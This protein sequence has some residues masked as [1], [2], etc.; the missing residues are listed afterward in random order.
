MY[1]NLIKFTKRAYNNLQ[2]RLLLRKKEE[3]II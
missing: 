3:K 1:L 2:R